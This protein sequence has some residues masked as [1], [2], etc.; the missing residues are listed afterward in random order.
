VAESLRNQLLL[1]LRKKL[2]RSTQQLSLAL[3]GWEFHPEVSHQLDLLR[4][5]HLVEYWDSSCRRHSL[6]CAGRNAA[7]RLVDRA[8]RKKAA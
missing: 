5:E 3:T 1:E 8:K 2:W 4:G 6:T 7:Q